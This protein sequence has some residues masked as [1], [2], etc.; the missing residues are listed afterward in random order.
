MQRQLF[1]DDTDS[2]PE[3]KGTDKGTG[4]TGGRTTAGTAIPLSG[5]GGGGLDGDAPRVA[6]AVAVQTP[7]PPSMPSPAAWPYADIVRMTFD[8]SAGP[9]VAGRRV[10]MWCRKV[11]GRTIK[12]GR[13]DRPADALERWRAEIGD[14]ETGAF[15]GRA[16]AAKWANR[17]P[18]GPVTV[19]EL[20]DRYL[21]GK[22]AAVERGE[23]LPITLA[24]YVTSAKLA[25]A[26]LGRATRVDALG[27]ERFESVLRRSTYGPTRRGCFVMHVK[28]AFR[29]GVDFGV[30]ER[31]P[32]YGPSFRGP[33][34]SQRRR[35][36]A[37]RGRN[38]FPADQ[39]RKLTD[40]ASVQMRAMLML[41][42]N[43]GFGNT[44]VA[45]L[46]IGDLRLDD[47]QPRIEYV[48]HK[49][50]IPRCVP[51]WGRTCD[52]M[53]QY[54]ETRPEPAD[55]AYADLVFLTAN[56]TGFGSHRCAALSSQFRALRSRCGLVPSPDPVYEP[57]GF[58]SFRHGFATMAGETGYA[59]AVA[60]ILGHA[61]GGMA[62]VYTEEL[63]IERLRTVTD[64]VESVIWS[65]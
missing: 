18:A 19:G 3:C 56:G 16:R 4:E 65:G 36:R 37:S 5:G 2:A 32:R 33:T 64:H 27:P 1:T 6:A 31:P 50:A 15:R 12:F 45:T 8:A 51:L 44:D 39:I 42:A 20:L 52:A 60:R 35:L 13:G 17:D 26:Q 23:L 29:W 11:R 57:R 9:V 55:A 30:I 34:A 22:S 63:R 58:A 46:S 59:H 48:R 47:D 38:M 24:D 10:G 14:L 43:G 49:T 7:A 25:G 53:R 54:R 21:D 40:A 28:Q 61:I 62:E 41:A